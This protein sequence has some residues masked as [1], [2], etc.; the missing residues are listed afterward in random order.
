MLFP[1]RMFRRWQLTSLPIPR[2]TA[3]RLSLRIPLAS[4]SLLPMGHWA[5]SQ[6]QLRQP[7]QHHSLPIHLG[8]LSLLP[9]TLC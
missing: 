2:Q 1:L 4:P 6:L 7:L 8:R 9:M 3:L 5:L